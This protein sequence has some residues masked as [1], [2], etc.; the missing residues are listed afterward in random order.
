MT[1]IMLD[2]TNPAAVLDAI[3]KGRQWRNMRIRAA[4]GYQDGHYAWPAELAGKVK[5]A[6]SGALVL[7]TV[8]NDRA[9][10]RWADDEPGDL[11]AHEATVY[12]QTEKDAHAWGV[13]YCDRVGKEALLTEAAAAGLRPG[14]DFGMW[15]ATLDGTFTDLDGSDLRGQE[16]VVAVQYL[17]DAR[18]DVDVSV[19][20]AAGDIWLGIGDTDAWVV[21]ALNG[22]K[23]LLAD[24]ASLQALLEMHQPK[25][26]TVDAPPRGGM[27]HAE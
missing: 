11:D 6:L 4:A 20:T 15:V 18:L 24:A 9:R 19:I 21:S 1:G 13:V 12:A 2:S 22:A 23:T 3:A 17:N 27:V 8:E 16:G 5:T 14:P 26:A 10:V 25:T 7:G